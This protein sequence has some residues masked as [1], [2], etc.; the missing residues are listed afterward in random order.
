M[1]KK[2]KI[3]KYIILL[4]IVLNTISTFSIAISD[5]YIWSGEEDTTDLSNIYLFHLYIT[6][7]L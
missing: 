5:Q 1:L 2:G 3:L 6:T 4:V 7:N